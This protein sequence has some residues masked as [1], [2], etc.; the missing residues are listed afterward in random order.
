MCRSIKKLRQP[1]A[2]PTDAEIQAA[3]LQFIRK[4]S[5]FQ[6]PSRA[7]QDSFDLA[8]AE[9]GETTRRLLDAIQATSPARARSLAPSGSDHAG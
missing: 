3:A 4:V 6:R 2:P 1:E 7:N 9:V 8:V 5:G